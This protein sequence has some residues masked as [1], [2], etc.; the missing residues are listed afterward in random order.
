MSDN[1]CSRCK[2]P[3]SAGIPRHKCWVNK[4]LLR[5]TTIQ[6]GLRFQLWRFAPWTENPW[7]QV[8]MTYTDLE[9]CSACAADV[10]LYAQGRECKETP[11]SFNPPAD[12]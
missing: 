4:A 3:L 2:N 5:R 6:H 7:E 11:E 12:S 9:L 1:N 8:R 10:F